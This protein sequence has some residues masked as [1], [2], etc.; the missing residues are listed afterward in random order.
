MSVWLWAESY[1]R[2]AK[3]VMSSLSRE[4]GLPQT[5]S[6]LYLPLSCPALD[7]LVVYITQGV[8]SVKT[9]LNGRSFS[10]HS[11]TISFVSF[12]SLLL[13]VVPPARRFSYLILL[14]QSLVF[15]DQGPDDWLRRR[16]SRLRLR[17]HPTINRSQLDWRVKKAKTI[18][19]GGWESPFLSATGKEKTIN[20]AVV[21]IV[22]YR[23]HNPTGDRRFRSELKGV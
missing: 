21:I 22:K 1:R 2:Q 12:V 7:G 19:G 13:I 16:R 3:V 15:T 4:L 9:F 23:R 5:L 6:T 17:F 8:N 14:F 11:F 10:S 18:K 20:H